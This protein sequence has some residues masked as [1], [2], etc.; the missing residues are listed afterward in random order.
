MGR[1]GGGRKAMRGSCLEDLPIGKRP[2][3]FP[4]PH[5]PSLQLTISGVS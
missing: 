3:P 2:A 5:Q 1:V 4:K